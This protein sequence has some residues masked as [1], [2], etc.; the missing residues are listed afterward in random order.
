MKIWKTVSEKQLDRVTLVNLV[1]KYPVVHEKLQGPSILNLKLKAW[2]TVAE[3]LSKAM[4]KDI[5]VGQLKKLPNHI[6]T[7]IKKKLI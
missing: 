3:K 7:V 1:A 2:L 6:K 4:G 5:Q